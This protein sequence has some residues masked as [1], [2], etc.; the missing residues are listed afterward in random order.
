MFCFTNHKCSCHN[1][2]SYVRFIGSISF[3]F[4]FSLQIKCWKMVNKW[5]DVGMIVLSDFVQ[6]IEEFQKCHIDHPIGKFFGECTD[7]KIKLDRC[8]R[9]E[10][11]FHYMGLGFLWLGSLFYHS[12]NKIFKNFD[13]KL[14]SGKQTL[15]RVRNWRKDYKLLGR[16]LLREALKRTTLC[17]VN[18][19]VRA[20]SW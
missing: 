13:R 9:E 5:I 2:D 3:P 18:G 6:I 20:S 11:S 15:S 19:E 16:K 10:V 17:K 4:F 14:W 12:H 8:F 1:F 7:L